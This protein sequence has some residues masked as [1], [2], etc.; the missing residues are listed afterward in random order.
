MYHND[1]IRRALRRI[2]LE[3]EYRTKVSHQHVHVPTITH[4]RRN[5]F[6]G[7]VSIVFNRN[8]NQ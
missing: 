2:L 7:P 3:M 4:I 5:Q 8:K 6:P 1:G